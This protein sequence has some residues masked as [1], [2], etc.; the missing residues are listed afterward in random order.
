MPIETVDH[1]KAL[2]IKVSGSF[3]RQASE[4]LEDAIAES[5]NSSEKVVVNLFDV[6]YISSVSIGT[7]VKLHRELSS[8]QKSLMISNV[9]EECQQIFDMIDMHEILDF[10][11]DVNEAIAKKK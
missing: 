8:D 3:D 2:E 7:L 1:D 6:N 11:E 9:S 5:D 10:Y 4:E